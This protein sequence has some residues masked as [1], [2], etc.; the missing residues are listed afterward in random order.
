MPAPPPQANPQFR[1]IAGVSMGAFGA[2]NLGTKHPDVFG[3]V[4]ALGGPVDMKQLLR[5]SIYENLEV[6]PQTTIP[7]QVGEDFTYDHLPPYPS[8][9]DRVSLSKDLMIAFGNPFLHHPDPTRQYLASD[10]EPARILKDDQFGD[11]TL[12]PSP[13]GFLDGGDTNSDG[14]RQTSEAATTPTDVL[15]LAG[16]SL[17][18]ISP[19]AQGVVVGD[20]ALADLN[21]DGVF[22]VGDGIVVNFSEPFTDNNQNGVFEPELG[23][24]FQDVGL[25]G[26]PGTGDFG[27]GNGKFD[28]DPDRQNW[29]DE[30]PLTRLSGEQVSD[31]ERQRIYMD[32]GTEDQFN[33]AQH[34]A[35]FVAML[36]GK[37]IAVDVHDGFSGNCTSV[38]D[39]SAQFV[40]F[41]YPGGHTG[42][43]DADSIV[44]D[45]ANGDFCGSVPIW[46]RLLTLIGWLNQSFP[47]G[48][49]GLGKAFD[50]N[51][52]DFDFS[53][54]DVR[55]DIV[56]RD[57]PSPAL[58]TAGGA[59]PN[60]HVVVYRPPKFSNTSA[61]FP[62]VYFLGGYGQSPDDYKRMRDFMDLLIAAKEVQNMYLA[63]L[64][65]TGG[66][67]G[68]FYVNHIVPEDQVPDVIGPTSG[69]YEDSLVQDLIPVVENDIADG[70][71]RE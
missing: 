2:M 24:T 37:G 56:D 54:L 19:G 41:R 13:R 1:A 47:G 43:P 48:N 7:R 15:L 20:R 27:E 34:Y 25:D 28:Y 52:N 11:F 58:A 62:I 59:A 49:F 69:R 68:S 60:Q 51:F 53:K 21:G 46:Q 40:L 50:F 30:D 66:V 61:S 3:V 36:Q 57:I 29:L 4:G 33:F 8:R 71:I 65:G 35:N 63:F 14:L 26:V 10:S 67:K 70:R 17:A 31:I 32:V 9:D 18:R 5:D 42:I 12:P 64:P 44:D 22:D 55:G 45:L 38:P 16:G 6:K 23:E 39:P